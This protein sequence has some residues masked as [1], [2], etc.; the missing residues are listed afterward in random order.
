MIA[1]I[2]DEKIIFPKLI[3]LVQKAA[4]EKRLHFAEVGINHARVYKIQLFPFCNKCADRKLFLLI[5]IIK[6]LHQTLLP[7]LRQIFSGIVD[8]AEI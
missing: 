4:H 3:N 7:I 8:G 2:H 6:Q 1:H 5:Q